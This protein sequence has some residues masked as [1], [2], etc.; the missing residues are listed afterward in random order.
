MDRPFDVTAFVRPICLPEPKLKL[1]PG[2]KCVT[3]GWGWTKMTSLLQQQ[4]ATILPYSECAEHKV[5]G[6]SKSPERFCV[7]NGCTCL[8]NGM[9]FV[10]KMGNK[11]EHK[12]YL[13]GVKVAD[14]KGIDF[15]Y[16][17]AAYRMPH[18]VCLI[19]TQFRK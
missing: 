18:T 9:P 11:L 1:K 4:I 15:K 6:R 14:G 5:Y 12:Y 16:P 8:E 10:C 13:T 2:L 17:Y 7:S 3:T 19:I